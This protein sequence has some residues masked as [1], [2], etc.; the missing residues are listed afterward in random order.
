MRQLAGSDASADYFCKP[1]AFP[2]LQ[3][4]W[5]LE[6]TLRPAPDLA[7]QRDLA[8]STMCGY[9]YIRM[10][11]N[12]MDG[13]ATVEPGLLGTFKMLTGDAIR[14]SEMGQHEAGLV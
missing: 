9:Y 13:H 3:L 6:R 10:I 7:L 8:R 2:M 4:P 1:H 14:T 5:W 12:V 11:D